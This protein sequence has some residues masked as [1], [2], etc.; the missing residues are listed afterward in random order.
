VSVG[1]ARF[2]LGGST[3]SFP[4]IE[5]ASGYTGP[6]ATDSVD[7]PEGNADMALV[8]VGIVISI[9]VPP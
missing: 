9:L 1:S 2:V 3:V 8:F 6:V 7:R 5:T 4:A